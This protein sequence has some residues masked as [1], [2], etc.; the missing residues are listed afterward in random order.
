MSEEEKQMLEKLKQENEELKKII[1]QH[2][3]S[4]EDYQTTIAKL[5]QLNKELSLNTDVKSEE[6]KKITESMSK[7]INRRG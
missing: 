7:L 5:K 3:K 6:D 4:E 2:E 1:S